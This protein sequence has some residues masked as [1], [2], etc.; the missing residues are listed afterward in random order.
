LLKVIEHD[1]APKVELTKKEIKVFI[2]PNSTRSKR[3]E[4][5]DE[6]YRTELKKILP[7]IIKKWE[8]VIGVQSNDYGIKKMRTKWGTCNR[9]AKRIWLNLELAK[10][11]VECIEYIVVHELVHFLERSHNE[12]FIAY[13]DK[14]MPKW[15]FHRDELNRLPFSHVD[16][17]Y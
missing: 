8:D 12:R 13:M 3:K 17:K 2:R 15:R 14:F 10:K 4:T 16:W 7:A 6:W 5:L 1:A 11:P 9:E